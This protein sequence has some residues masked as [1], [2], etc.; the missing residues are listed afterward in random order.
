MGLSL[1]L[2]APSPIVTAVFATALGFVISAGVGLY[3]IYSSILDEDIA[4]FHVCLWPCEVA[5]AT[6]VPEEAAQ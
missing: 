3:V 4:D 5:I 1:G 6:V 2:F